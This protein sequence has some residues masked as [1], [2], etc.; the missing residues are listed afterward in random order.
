MPF[1]VCLNLLRFWESRCSG[2]IDAPC[3]LEFH[4]ATSTKLAIWAWACEP[5][6]AEIAGNKIHQRPSKSSVYNTT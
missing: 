6:A 4:P 2:E 3:N 5:L 1:S